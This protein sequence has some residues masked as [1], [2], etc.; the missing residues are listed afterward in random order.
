MDLEMDS[1]E[2][3]IQLWEKLRSLAPLLKSDYLPNAI[4]DDSYLLENGKEISRIYVELSDVSIH[5]KGSWQETMLFLNKNM[6]LFETFFES[7]KEVI[8]S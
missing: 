3:R 8:N 5:N 6:V 7:Y 2:K 4:F 1:L